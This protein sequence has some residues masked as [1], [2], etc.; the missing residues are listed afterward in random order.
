MIKLVGVF[1]V[2]A[3]L[4]TGWWAV[5]STMMQR[6][7]SNWLE[8]R[9][10]LGW[11]VDVGTVQKQGF[12]M[13][14]RVQMKDLAL[15][16]P[17]TGAALDMDRFNISTPSYWPGY[18]TV[19]L[20][21]TPITVTTGKLSAS[22]TA[23]D[24]VADLRLRPGI[25]LEMESLVLAG[26]AWALDTA[27]GQLATAKTIDLAMTQQSAGSPTYDIKVNSDDLTPGSVPRAFLGLPSDWPLAFDAFKADLSVTFDTLW[28]RRALGRNRPQPRVIDLKQAQIVWSDIALLAS[29]NVTVDKEGLATGN[30][31]IKAEN[32]P[33]LLDM[34]ENAG[35][36]PPNMRPQAEQM[37]TGLSQMSG[38][39]NALDLTLSL[40]DGRMSMGFIPLGRAPRII[41]R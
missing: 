29:G 32:W 23:R 36:L 1:A 15:L 5:A 4:W 7:V 34:V 27:L 24:A 18:V 13:R 35:Y 9:R 14:L 21:E 39:T 25:S 17:T 37:L 12:P 6:G 26:G 20:P 19:P 38:Q 40:Q 11:Q 33:A 41:L 31:S 30:L 8:T 3:I 16:N 10:A 22:L 2:F 28:D